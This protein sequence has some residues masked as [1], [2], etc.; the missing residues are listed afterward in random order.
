[1][2]VKTGWRTMSTAGD[3]EGWSLANPY[4]HCARA[5]IIIAKIAQLVQ[6]SVNI[7]SHTANIPTGESRCF[8]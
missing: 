2:F 7:P 6:M 4:K 8:Q 3:C 5:A 1:M